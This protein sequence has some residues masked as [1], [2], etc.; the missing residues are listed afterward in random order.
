MRAGGLGCLRQGL[1]VDTSVQVIRPSSAVSSQPAAAQ[2]VTIQ[3][4]AGEESEDFADGRLPAGGL[5]QRH[6]GLDLI[7]VAAAVFVLHHVAS[8][9]EIGDDAMGAALGDTQA[10]RDVTQP[11]PGITGDTQQHTGVIGQESPARHP[12]QITRGTSCLSSFS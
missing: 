11:D 10:V 5:R 2:S 8:F 6:V 7:A 12:R 1:T 3:R 9:G 4:C